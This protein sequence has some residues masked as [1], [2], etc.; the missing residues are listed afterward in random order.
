[1]KK[2]LL[3]ILIVTISSCKTEKKQESENKIIEIEN[4]EL[5][6]IYENDQNDRMTDNINWY[7]VNKRDSLRRVRVHQL[8]DSGKVKTGKDLKNAAMVFQHGNDST[9]YGLAVILMKKA[10]KKDT[11]INKWLFAAATDRYLLSKNEPQIYGT[12]YQ[13]M[14]EEPWKLGEIDTTKISDIERFEYGV[15]TLAE[16]RLKVKEM[17]SEN[18]GHE[19]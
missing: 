3:L 4:T 6:E 18:H 15:E 7:E 10:I 12:Q 14:G 1:M 5:I 9:D 16:Q 11:T 2:I 17:N 8:L 13:K 19:H